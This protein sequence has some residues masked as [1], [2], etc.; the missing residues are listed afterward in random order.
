MDEAE[1]H[2]DTGITEILPVFYKLFDFSLQPFKGRIR[3]LKLKADAL[4]HAVT[5]VF[6]NSFHAKAFVIKAVHFLIHRI[7]TDGSM[8]IFVSVYR[9]HKAGEVAGIIC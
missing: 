1:Y 7:Q 2:T 8:R 5:F 4:F 3:Y 6:G 9:F